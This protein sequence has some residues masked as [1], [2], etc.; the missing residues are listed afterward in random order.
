MV[1]RQ[2]KIRDRR[3]IVD[4]RVSTKALLVIVRALM[5][6]QEGTPPK[7]EP[8]S[9]IYHFQNNNKAKIKGS[10]LFDMH[11]QSLYLMGYHMHTTVVEIQQ[12]KWSFLGKI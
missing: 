6:E 10:Y 5:L 8:A 12:N 11:L 4:E 7:S 2:S 1:C 3:D 9:K